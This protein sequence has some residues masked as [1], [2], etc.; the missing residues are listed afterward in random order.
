MNLSRFQ[1]RA[2]PFRT[3]PDTHSYYPA[4]PHESVLQH[5]DQAI[6]DEEGFVLATGDAGVGKTLVAHLLL[7]RLGEKVAS[8]LLTNCR[9]ACRADMLRS[10][11]FDLGQPHQ[12]LGEQE[13]RLALTDHLLSQLAARKT[14]LLVLDEAQGLN[15]DLLEE[16]RLLGNLETS[17]GKAVQI[18]LLAQPNLLQTLG[19]AELAALNQRLAVR[20]ELEAL[21][22][23]EGADYVLH[24][25]RVAGG[26]PEAIISHEAV[27]V[28]AKNSR[29]IPRLLNQMG[30]LALSIA[31]A[32]GADLVDVEAALEALT[33]LGIEPINDDEGVESPVHL[34][35]L[36]TAPHEHGTPAGDYVFS[37]RVNKSA[38]PVDFSPQAQA[39]S[40]WND[41]GYSHHPPNTPTAALGPS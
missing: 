32:A 18:I 12:G 23:H 4:T 27:T 31:D 35:K 25:L 38:P 37:P 1:L 2:R 7:A 41:A 15:S 39:D 8:S 6:A 3:T 5:L 17:N 19:R 28:L 20:L 24:Q 34:A 14:T 13:L 30:H 29:G 16:L 11:L 36:V 22:I 33:M 40:I 26:R 21:N 10:I 9:F